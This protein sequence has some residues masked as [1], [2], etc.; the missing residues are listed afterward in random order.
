M[1]FFQSVKISFYAE[2]V[3]V[4]WRKNGSFG[5]AKGR[6]MLGK[7]QVCHFAGGLFCP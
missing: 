5:F 6:L 1:F 4:R 7:N 2:T 3:L